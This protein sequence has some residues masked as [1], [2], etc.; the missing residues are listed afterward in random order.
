M[1]NILPATLVTPAWYRGTGTIVST[2]HM[3]AATS[4]LDTGT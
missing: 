3:S 2:V 4:Y 1:R